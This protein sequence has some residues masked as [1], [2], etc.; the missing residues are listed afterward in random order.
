LLVSWGLAGAFGM[1][2]IPGAVVGIFFAFLMPQ[3]GALYR[4]MR[5]EKE[6]T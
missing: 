1:M 5:D 2:L 3:W 4:K 6:G